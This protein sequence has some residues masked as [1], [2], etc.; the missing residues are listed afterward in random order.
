MANIAISLE[1]IE[2]AIENLKY[3]PGSIK[4]K[5]LL[6]IRAFYNSDD[7]L[8]D[9]AWIGRR[10]PTVTVSSRALFKTAFSSNTIGFRCI[11]EIC[12]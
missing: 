8:A 3:R 5:T 12:L 7:A 10:I 1:G 2:Q 9:A 11:S 6:A 4:Q